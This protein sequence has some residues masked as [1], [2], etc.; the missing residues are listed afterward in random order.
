M[1]VAL[2][3]RTRAPR[4]R[5][6]RRGVRL[7]CAPRA[8]AVVAAHPRRSRSRRVGARRVRREA[9][10]A[11][12][13]GTALRGRHGARVRKLGRGG[14]RCGSARRAAPASARHRRA[15]A[16]GPVVGQPPAPREGPCRPTHRDVAGHRP[17]GRPGGIGDHVRHGGPVGVA[18][19]AP[20]GPRPDH[21]RRD[22]EGPRAGIG[23]RHAPQ[24]DPRLPR[25]M[26]WPTVNLPPFFFLVLGPNDILI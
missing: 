16:G 19:P 3:Q 13:A 18:R 14:G 11:H 6:P 5:L 25:P 12:A 21:H 26:I 9:R 8:V 4:R 7:V 10:P 23:V 17:G 24:R 15:G 1:G 22:G 2:P 20:S